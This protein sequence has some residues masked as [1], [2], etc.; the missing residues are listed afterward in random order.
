MGQVERPH[1][2]ALS[3]PW[4]LESRLGGACDLLYHSSSFIFRMALCVKA[5]GLTQ[6]FSTSLMPE[7]FHTAPYAAVT[8][9]P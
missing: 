4:V 6:W 9:R 1:P 7:P 5:K 8:S 2:G 3:G